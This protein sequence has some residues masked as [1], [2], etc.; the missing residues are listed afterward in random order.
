MHM[1]RTRWGHGENDK[2]ELYE[3]GEFGTRPGRSRYGP[4]IDR[5]GPG[6]K[7]NGKKQFGR[8]ISPLVI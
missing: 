4:G 1:V 8:E 2:L 3:D 7:M 6:D 5:Y